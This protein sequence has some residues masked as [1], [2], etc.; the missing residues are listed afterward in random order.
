M[1]LIYR[2][3]ALDIS[4]VTMRWDGFI[5]FFTPWW[6]NLLNI[7]TILTTL[8]ILC[9]VSCSVEVFS[10]SLT[11]DWLVPI[12][13][14]NGSL[15]LTQHLLISASRE[16]D[17]LWSLWFLL[18]LMG[19]SLSTSSFGRRKGLCICFTFFH[20]LVFSNSCSWTPYNY[21][22]SSSE[23]I[24]A[25]RKCVYSHGLDCSATWVGQI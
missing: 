25:M 8:I 6:R 14:W 11:H 13:I 1:L 9:L 15:S 2:W 16:K 23:L 21:H 12:S 18:G 5:L 24:E 3:K 4:R 19:F 10:L 20:A 17:E 22:H 7:W